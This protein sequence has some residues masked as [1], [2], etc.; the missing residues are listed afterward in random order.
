VIRPS[1]INRDIKSLNTASI[2]GRNWM[3]PTYLL[4][5]AAVVLVGLTLMSLNPGPAQATRHSALEIPDQAISTTESSA[6]DELA[7]LTAD[8]AV[9]DLSGKTLELDI[10]AATGQNQAAAPADE[11]WQE[12]TVKNGDSLASIF[13]HLGI[14]PQELHNLLQQGGATQNLQKIFPGQTLRVIT[15]DSNQLVKL[16]YPIDHLNTLEVVRNGDEF[17]VSTVTQTPEFRTRNANGTIESSLFLAGNKAGLSDSMTMELASIFAWDIDF[18]LDI[19]EG[20]K[21]TVIY[22]DMY[23]DGESIGNETILAAEFINQ[24]KRYQAIRY[25]DAGGKTDYYSP[26]GKSMRKEFLRTPVEFSRISSGFSLGRF[27]PILNK[28]RAHKGVDYA[29][30]TGTPIKA[31]GDGKITFRGRKGGYGNVIILQHG[32]KYS[33]LYGH[34]SKFRGGLATGSRV[35]QGQVIGYVGMTGLATGP[36]L[37]YEFRIDGVHHDPLRVKLPGADPL[38]E[39]YRADFNSK[40]KGLIAK[41]DLIRDVQV[42]A[43]E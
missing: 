15:G 42:A 35:R 7:S 36:H 2:P 37:H 10:P 41:L 22:E 30:P 23:V 4:S 13:S 17:D 34:M 25:T 28:I 9:P 1:I 6:A 19:R 18:A 3:N 40:A 11:P 20:D 14:S 33:T 32:A 5:A 27:H 29:A 24:G 38:S 8:R 16:S 31:T 12:V 39:K 26:D 21:F 43:T